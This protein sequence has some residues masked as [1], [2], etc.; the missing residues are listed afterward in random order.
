M[1]RITSHYLLAILCVMPPRILLFVLA[2]N[3]TLLAYV[4]LA[5]N[6]DPDILFCKDAFSSSSFCE[7]SWSP[8]YTG[9]WGCSSSDA[10]LALPF[11][12]LSK[13]PACPF[14]QPVE[15]PLDGST[16][17]WCISHSSQ[18]YVLS[19]LAESTRCPVIQI[20]NGGV[21]QH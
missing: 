11:A 18:F 13:V 7:A 1:G 19:N 10:E 16:T 6:Q 12:E 14:L 5:V 9:A 21:D 4:S 15:V 3:G 8:A 17:L 20:M 2:A